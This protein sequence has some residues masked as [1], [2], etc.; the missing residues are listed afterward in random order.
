MLMQNTNF[1]LLQNIHHQT[2][3]GTD[4]AGTISGTALHKHSTLCSYIVHVY[5]CMYMYMQ[6]IVPVLFRIHV[7]LPQCIDVY[8]SIHVVADICDGDDATRGKDIQTHHPLHCE[9]QQ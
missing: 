5:M 2:I 4:S 9:C 8:M 3:V 7:H 6:V 1:S